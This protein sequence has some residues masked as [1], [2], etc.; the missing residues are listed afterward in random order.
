M[1]KQTKDIDSF[2][3]Y[4]CAV[5]KV[6]STLINVLIITP[7]VAMIQFLPKYIS[8][9]WLITVVL[10][11]TVHLIYYSICIKKKSVEFKKVKNSIKTLYITLNILFISLS[12]II[13]SIL[14]V[15][16]EYS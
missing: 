8:T 13:A 12:C 7:S 2:S 1:T 5:N 10:L 4:L 11:F 14:L 3:K 16:F 6:I 9:V 15:L